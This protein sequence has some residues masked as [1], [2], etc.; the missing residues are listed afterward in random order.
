MARNKP[1]YLEIGAKKGGMFLK[2]K[3][4]KK[5]AV[6]PVFAFDYVSKSRKIS[7]ILRN[8][9]NLNNNYFEMSS[10]YFF[11]RC[12]ELLQKT[13]IDVVFI[14]GLH[15]YQQSLRDVENCLKYLKPDGVIAV[16]DCNPPFAAAGH[17]AESYEHAQGLALSGWTGEW[18]G[19]VWKTILFLRSTRS[20]LDVFVLDCDYGVALITKG[21]PSVPMEFDPEKI[22]D[23]T[24]E[25]LEI[26]RKEFL[27]LRPVSFFEEWM[28]YARTFRHL[29]IHH[30][31]HCSGI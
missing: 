28:R 4:R 18:C 23:L 11:R 22:E 6:D 12:D 25:D 1:T 14:D 26:N 30:R 29:P 7:H 27:D 3:A 8:F 15:T 17:P 16:H 24:Y 10:D 19:D 2:I 5:I 21:D 9:S 20:D 31:L 13:K